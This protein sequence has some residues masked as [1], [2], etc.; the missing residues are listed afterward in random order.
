[1]RCIFG[2]LVLLMAPLTAQASSPDAWEQFRQ[3]VKQVCAEELA[4]TEPSAAAGIEVN[5]FGSQSYGAALITLTRDEGQP[6]RMICIYDKQAGTA[7][8]TGPFPPED[9]P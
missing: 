9:Q 2:S 6:E 5:P 7:E 1:M 8:I 4:Q 3:D